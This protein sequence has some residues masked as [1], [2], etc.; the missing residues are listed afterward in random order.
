MLVVGN[1]I[2][3]RNDEKDEKDEKDEAEDVTEGASGEERDGGRNSSSS[4]EG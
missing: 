2:V 4:H 3:G 1:V